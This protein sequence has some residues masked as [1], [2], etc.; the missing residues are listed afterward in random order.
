[1]NWPKSPVLFFDGVCNLCNGAVQFI[2]THEKEQKL[3]FSPL[4]S[5]MGRKLQAFIPPGTDS[6]VLY[7]D[8]KIYIRSSAA[9]RVASYLKKPYSFLRSL[10]IIPTFIRDLLYRL[11]ARQRYVL[12][13]R[14]D[15]CMMPTAELK[16]RFI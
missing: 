1:M 11:I 7:E 9:L 2:L 14:K 13:G 12:F 3:L 8:G 6:L 5:E 16:K 15:S 10:V 4:Q